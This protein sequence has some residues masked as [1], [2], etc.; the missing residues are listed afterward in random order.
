M[1]KLL[2]DY[3]EKVERYLKPLPISERADIVKEIKSE[4]LELQSSGKT[5]EE[6]MERLGNPKELARAYLG[7]LISKSSSFC[8]SR[9]LAICAFY[10]LTSFSG[11]FV[12]P[13]LGIC[14]PVFM[15]CAVFIPIAG[16]IRLIDALPFLSIPYA[17]N[18]V[19]SGVENPILIFLVCLIIS[20]VMFLIGYGCWKLLVG[21]IKAVSKTKQR[22]S[23]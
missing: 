6:I 2:N 1:D 23:L 11:L 17:E 14:A 15:L 4:I 9:I 7:D 21:Y 12:I 8:W 18:I 10:S 20:V 22:L 3:L 19:V 16:I 5:S 13:V